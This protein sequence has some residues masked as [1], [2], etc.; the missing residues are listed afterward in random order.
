MKWVLG[1]FSCLLGLL[2]LSGSFHSSLAYLRDSTSPAKEYLGTPFDK[3]TSP[4]WRYKQPFQRRDLNPVPSNHPYPEPQPHR[5]RPER[6]CLGPKG[7]K[8]YV[9]LAGTEAFPGKQIAVID[10]G[11]RKLIKKIEVGSR[12]YMSVLH[13]AGR[14]LVVINEFSNYATVID[15]TRDEVSGEIPLDYY[16]QG[17]VFT[18]DGTT[19]YV[20]NR[21]LD[22]VLVLRLIQK[23]GNL[24]G[25]VE[26]QGGFSEAEFLGKSSLSEVEKSRLKNL[27]HSAQRVQEMNQ[28]KRGGLNSILR[29]RCA[30]CH[31]ESAGGFLCG[32]DPVE[33]FL[34]AIENS[35]G[36]RPME[37]PLLKAVVSSGMGGYGDQKK[38]TE[39]H[40]GGVLFQ[41]GEPALLD[42]VRWIK[43]GEGGPGIPVSNPGSHPKDLAL[44]P[45]ENH[46]FIGNTGTQDLSVIDLRTHREAG[47][48]FLQN[49]ASHIEVVSHPEGDG[50]LLVALS[51]GVG[52]GAPKSRDPLGA[53][54]WNKQNS[55]AQ[56][57]V[58][59]D[60]ETTDALPL[61]KQFV[62]GSFD[63]VDGTW[64]FKMRD[65][66]ND[67][68]AI[69]LDRLKIP[70]RESAENLE[71]ILLA[72][73]YEAHPDW[74]RYTS[75]SA[76][77]TVGDIKGDIPPQL[78][79]V[80]GAFPE[81]SVSDGEY[82]YVSMAGTFEVIQ[83]KIHWG[84]REPS[85]LLEPVRS[86]STGL[87]PMGLALG[88]QGTSSE[89]L[90]F[91]ANQL[92]ETVSFIDLKTG[93]REDV[94]VGNLKRPVL[95]TDAEKGELVVHSSVFTSDGD[96]SCLHCHY[97][98]TG[99]G[100]GWGAAETVGQDQQG[101]LTPGGT[102]G[103]P[104]MR[105]LFAIQPFYF[106]GTH[107]IGEG[108]GADINE[109]ASS[110][111]FDREVWTAD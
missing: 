102:L 69:D 29:A 14:F 64:N 109:P 95:D 6:P 45:D 2:Y 61:E 59:R 101:H 60:P 49:L 17:I 108:Q 94:I 15:T 43:N 25:A 82:L 75:D 89:G 19:A 96:T 88:V 47:G 28:T 86:F 52:F 40:P 91:C 106:E 63:A 30:S 97:R 31:R 50:N 33:N 110:I 111:D 105:N 11:S 51:L 71:Y 66:Q 39:F 83:W 1:V 87:R 42:L 48:I 80:P 99:D 81:W 79:R 92:S 27:G 72:N 103:I 93:E 16:C 9:T 23:D 37:S 54:T 78:Q 12:P 46:L 67:L 68:I 57:T 77:A 62:M 53:E 85:N 55:A 90:L 70:E 104:Q 13:P 98:D 20:A 44:S 76:E 10:V 107:L 35:V 24:L 38:R 34:S 4:V 5:D 7:E 3:L 100:R 36:G 8:L 26:I 18:K 73:T 84:I 32:A 21:Y 22:Q 74:V 65:I 58:L 56:F 41:E